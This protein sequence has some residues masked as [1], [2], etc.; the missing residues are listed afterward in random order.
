MNNPINLYKNFFSSE[1]CDEI[2]KNAIKNFEVDKRTEGGWH[3]KTNRDSSFENYIHNKLEKIS[4]LNPFYIVW[5]NLT[6]YENDRFLKLHYDKRSEC[7]FTIVLTE[8]YTGGDFLIEGNRYPLT[9]GEC[10]SFNGF[11]LKHGVDSVTSGY[12]AALNVWIKEGN[13]SLL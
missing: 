9:K 10:I 7:T 11:Y 6:E 4:P 5:I 8:D 1:E 2:L 13:K 12:R 3:A